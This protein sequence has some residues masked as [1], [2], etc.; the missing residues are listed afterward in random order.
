MT[1]RDREI[2]PE[3]PAY[4]IGEISCNHM[5]SY[6]RAERIVRACADDGMD[7]VKIQLDNP[8]GGITLNCHDEHFTIRAGL[9]KG[10]NLHDFYSDPEHHTPWEWT[11]D[12]RDLAHNLGLAFIASVTCGGGVHECIQHNVDAIKIGAPERGD[13]PLVRTA[14]MSGIPVIV[15]GSTDYRNTIP[16]WVGRYAADDIQLP[17]FFHDT[18]HGYSDHSPDGIGNLAV[19]RGAWVI[20]RHVMDYETSMPADADFSTDI[21]AL[22]DY[23]DAIREA[24]IHCPK[25][26]KPKSD[27]DDSYSK[28]LHIAADMKM[29]DVFTANNLRSVR[30]SGGLR[31]GMYYEILGKRATRDL[32]F[33]APLQWGMWE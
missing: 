15:S 9:W 5:G 6:D 16:L 17:Y 32:A 1:I 3:H 8:D 33:G 28:S 24:E 14:I 20:E 30:P 19:A 4:L 13:V 23:I 21:L 25:V 11:P 12:L 22:D 27:I 18:W 31:P 29:G 10:H 7:A 26:M 2:G